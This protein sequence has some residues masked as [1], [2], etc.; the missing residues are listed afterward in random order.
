MKRFLLLLLTLIPVFIC[1]TVWAEKH[2]LAVRQP[3]QTNCSP[4]HGELDK[5][6]GSGARLLPIRPADHTNGTTMNSRSDKGIADII[7]KGG[8]AL[9]KTPYMPAWGGVLSEQ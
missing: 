9:G 4:C 6:D 7:S 5:G 8:S 3:Y 2:I 1:K